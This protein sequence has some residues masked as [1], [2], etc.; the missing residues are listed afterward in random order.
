MLAAQLKMPLQDVIGYLEEDRAKKLKDAEATATWS[1]RLPRL[2]P[3]FAIAAAGLVAATSGALNDGASMTA[4]Q[5]AALP[6]IHY[7]K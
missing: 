4:S 6:A 3:S 2:L 1:A 7:A 5:I